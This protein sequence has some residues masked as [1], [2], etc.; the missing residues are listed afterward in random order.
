[1]HLFFYV[2]LELFRF[3]S[4]AMV[5]CCLCFTPF[6]LPWLMREIPHKN[7]KLL[8]DINYP[9]IC[10]NELL[11]FHHLLRINKQEFARTCKS[12][13]IFPLPMS[14]FPSWKG[15]IASPPFL[16]CCLLPICQP[17]YIYFLPISSPAFPT[18]PP[19]PTTGTHYSGKLWPLHEA[20]LG[21]APPIFLVSPSVG[22]S[23]TGNCC[24]SC[25]I[26][27]L[28]QV[29]LSASPC[30]GV[31]R[32]RASVWLTLWGDWP[33]ASSCLA[34]NGLS[35]ASPPSLSCPWR[36]MLC[37]LCL[38]SGWMRT[39]FP[40]FHSDGEGIWFNPSV[41]RLTGPGEGADH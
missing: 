39:P 33:G 34:S 15:P 18:L 2:L 3:L 38:A 17:T 9:S 29:L 7:F 37:L 16:P 35:Q 25:F 4:C 19:F 21:H 11:S 30:I 6:L 36:A 26:Q 12:N 40:A 41:R 32:Q 22:L 10:V 1:M 8:R 28:A 23:W 20:Q 27:G 13:F 5:N 14:S 31:D 24:L